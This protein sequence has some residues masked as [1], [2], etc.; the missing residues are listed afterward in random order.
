MHIFLIIYL[1]IGGIYSLMAMAVVVLNISSLSH[2]IEVSIMALMILT[3]IVLIF[4][5]P[6]ELVTCIYRTIKFNKK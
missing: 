5:W 2:N 6:I 1:I 3:A 4:T